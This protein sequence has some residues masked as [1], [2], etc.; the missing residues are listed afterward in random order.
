MEA[1][2]GSRCRKGGELLCCS[3]C[4]LVYH[5]GCLDP[6]LKEVSV[7]LLLLRR[8]RNVSA[9]CSKLCCYVSV[10]SLL[11]PSFSPLIFLGD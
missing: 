5:L 9:R 11:Y 2:S 8:G 1:L 3:G 4:T 10:V 6:P 7:A